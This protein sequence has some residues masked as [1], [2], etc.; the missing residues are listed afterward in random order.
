MT[1]RNVLI[2]ILIGIALFLIGLAYYL[3]GKKG[4]SIVSDL[5]EEIEEIR[6]RPPRI[7]IDTVFE[8]DTVKQ[9]FPR[10]VPVPYPVYLKDSTV[11]NFYAD[12][13]I[14]PEV[15]IYIDD[16][17]KGFILDRRIAFKLKVP[18]KITKYETKYV[19][20]PVPVDKPVQAN[21]LFLTGGLGGGS[22]F[23][24]QFGGGFKYKRN[25]FG[26]S[27]LRYGEFNNVL[28]SYSFLITQQY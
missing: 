6:N 27:Y 22:E 16:T 14:T 21:G 7:E 5:V 11:A 24:Y 1:M 3:G 13:L 23:M 15:D 2:G 17:V 19:D 12:S 10:E 25:M 18:L 28:F 26:V 9:W 20:I 8:Y 4:E